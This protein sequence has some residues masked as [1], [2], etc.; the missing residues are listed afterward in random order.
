MFNLQLKGFQGNPDKG[1]DAVLCKL[2]NLALIY[3]WKLK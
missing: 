2:D 1:F 3:L